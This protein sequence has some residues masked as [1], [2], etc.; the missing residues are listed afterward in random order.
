MALTLQQTDE[1]VAT[2]L[3]RQETKLINQTI[4]AVPVW[5]WLLK[6]P[7]RQSVTGGNRV[8]FPVIKSNS[9]NFGWF[10]MGDTFNPQRNDILGWSYANLKQGAGDVTLEWLELKQNSGPGQFVS[11]LEAKVSELEQTIR[12]NL[13]TN[14]WSDGTGSGGKE[15]VGLTG[16]IPTTPTSGTYMG[17]SRSTNYWTRIW[18]WNGTNVGPH[19]LDQDPSGGTSLSS[20]GAII[21]KSAKYPSI[22]TYLYTMWHAC[23]PQGEDTSGIF[24]ITDLQT[25][26][27]YLQIP[28]Y[29][30][31]FDI[32]KSEGEFNIGFKGASFMGRP[33]MW[34]TTD[35]GAPAGEIRLVNTNYY[36]MYV[37]TSAFFKWTDW[38]SPYDALVQAK[39]LLVR[40]CTVDLM[41]RRHGIL[42]GVTAPA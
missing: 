32:G 10:G 30:P 21:D 23:V 17:W 42:T 39:Y 26:E 4:L 28:N 7:K 15:P 36:V 34:D 24:L 38:R 19:P 9:D 16:H 1:I 40:F 37:D 12:Q 6:S 29:C 35:N 20:V 41:P 25:Y 31:G 2:T 3:D 33:L 13:N 11:L 22:Q 18:F 5:E 8:R 14:A 27:W